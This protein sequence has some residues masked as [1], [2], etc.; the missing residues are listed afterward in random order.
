MGEKRRDDI[1]NVKR[2]GM[3]LR[4]DL[5]RREQK[6]R[7]AGKHDVQIEKVIWNSARDSELSV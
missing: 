4:D 7:D 3:V 2:I 6:K 1:T 5:R